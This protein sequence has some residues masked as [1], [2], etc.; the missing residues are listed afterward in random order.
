MEISRAARETLSSFV[1]RQLQLKTARHN[2]NYEK[3]TLFADH[4]PGVFSRG[5]KSRLRRNNKNGKRPSRSDWHAISPTKSIGRLPECK[6]TGPCAVIRQL[7][8][9]GGEGGRR[10]CRR[11]LTPQRPPILERKRVKDAKKYDLVRK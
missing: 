9:R 5:G 1:S 11:P 3:I 6:T 8:A 10:L 4:L 2:V 7:G